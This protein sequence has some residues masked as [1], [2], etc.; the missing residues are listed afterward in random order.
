[1]AD[2]LGSYNEYKINL[3][4]WVPEEEPEKIIPAEK[5]RGPNGNLT[6]EITKL[7]PYGDLRIEFSEDVN[8]EYNLTFLNSSIS[9]L[10]N[11]TKTRRMQEI[12]DHYKDV[13]DIYV[14]P[15]DDWIKYDE[16]YT[17]GFINLTWAAAS[18]SGKILEIKIYFE[19]P[20]EISPLTE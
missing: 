7:T 8:T 13:M 20:L 1:M 15:A 4:L 19:H 2:E 10:K 16:N 9:F 11:E 6:A 12:P 3:I 14:K 18:F 17:E 5:V